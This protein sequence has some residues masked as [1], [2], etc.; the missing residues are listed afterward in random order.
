MFDVDQIKIE[1]QREISRLKQLLYQKEETIRALQR[2]KFAI[3]ENLQCFWET[4]SD[5]KKVK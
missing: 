2:E 3:Q 5:G 4:A 1:F